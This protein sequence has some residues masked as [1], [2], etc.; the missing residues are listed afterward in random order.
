MAQTQHQARPTHETSGANNAK[1]SG[2]RRALPAL[3]G[4]LSIAVLAVIAIVYLLIIAPTVFS[5]SQANYQVATPSEPVVADSKQRVV[6]DTLVSDA[7]TGSTQDPRETE[8]A[9]DPARRDWV[10]TPGDQKVVYLT[11]D[12][13]PSSNTQ[14][15]LDILERYGIKASFFVTG[16]NPEY[17]PMIRECHM[18]GHTIG[19]HTWSHDYAQV[20]A[21]KEAFWADLDTIGMAVRDQIGYV[22]CFIRFPGGSSNTVSASYTKGIM[23]ELANEVIERGYQYYEWDASCGD[24]AEHTAAELIEATKWDTSY[25]YTSIVFLLH[26]GAGKETTVEALPGIIEYFQSEGYSFA[27]LDRFTCVAHHGIGN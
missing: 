3:I 7:A 19:L 2:T 9:V 25:G 6:E 27:P 21:S 17:L 13:G 8:F 4:M 14:P 20:Y 5:S 24:G 22:P 1:S 26:D 23:S 18:R 12:D 10:F 16:I 15:V 11:F